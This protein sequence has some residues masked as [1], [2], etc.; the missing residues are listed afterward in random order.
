MFYKGQIKGNFFVFYFLGNM[1]FFYDWP[2]PSKLII[3]SP[4]MVNSKISQNDEFSTFPQ[5]FFFLLNSILNYKVLKWLV[6]K[7]KLQ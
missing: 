6:S 3:K 7:I 2:L 5:C 1:F 4:M